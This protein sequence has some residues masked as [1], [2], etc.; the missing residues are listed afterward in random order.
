MPGNNP[1]TYLRL[2]GDFSSLLPFLWSWIKSFG[3]DYPF[4]TVED[5]INGLKNVNWLVEGSILPKVTDETI[6]RIFY[7]PPFEH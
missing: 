1:Q 7:S 3:T 5:S 4:T 6:D 2:C